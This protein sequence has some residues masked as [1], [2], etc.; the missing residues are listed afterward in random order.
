MP[1]I[2]M[3]PGAHILKHGE[4]PTIEGAVTHSEGHRA[5]R[6]QAGKEVKTEVGKVL[7]DTGASSTCFDE[8]IA[9]KLDLAIVGFGPQNTPSGTVPKSPRYEGQVIINSHPF[10]VERA[11]EGFLLRQGLIAL[12]GRDILSLGKLEYDG[13]TGIVTFRF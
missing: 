6:A 7:W 11:G 13:R 4:G 12:I 8:S 1:V 5:S 10:H 9:K 2:S 3:R